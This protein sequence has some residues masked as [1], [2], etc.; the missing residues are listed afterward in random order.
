[1]NTLVIILVVLAA[2]AFGFYLSRRPQ[3]RNSDS[4]T[5][6]QNQISEVN[7]TLESR[8]SDLP[9]LL[10][11]QFSE[12]AKII[13]NVTDRLA[14]LDETNRQVM[15]F[16]DE[17]KSL[18]DILKN[19]KQRGVLGEYYL[20]TV[21]SN[22]LP[23]G[24]FE[25]QHPFKDGNVVDAVIFYNNRLIPIDS[26]FSL[27][28]YNRLIGA[29]NP[30]ERKKLEESLRRD[31]KER[32]DETAKYIRPGEDTIDFAFMFIPSEA[33]YYDLLI[34]KVGSVTARDLIEYATAE[35]RVF[36]VSPTSFLAYLQTVIQ[37]LRQAEFNRSAEE[38]RKRVGDLGRHLLT[39][40]SFLEKLGK[41]LG[42][43]LNAYNEAA[44]EFQKID[45]DVLKITG[46]SAGLKPKI[47]EATEEK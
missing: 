27:E 47:D 11:T 14:K 12:S 1:M 42:T 15:G 23:P 30:E 29:K 36:V 21:L 9:R 44:N 5:L 40:N 34:N 19:P 24:S 41:N 39:F 7:R 35:K 46:E 25:M 22:V 28:N 43:A 18:Q 16:A 20:E 31:L 3:S 2:V 13:R 32:I 26:K 10:Q 37:G 4:L 8:L 33:L 38:I 17:L 45:K 6:L